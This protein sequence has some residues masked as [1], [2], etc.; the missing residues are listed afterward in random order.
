MDVQCFALLTF[1]LRRP[2]NRSVVLVKLSSLAYGLS[3]SFVL[4]LNSLCYNVEFL[5][6]GYYI[7]VV[8][9]ISLQCMVNYCRC[10]LNSAQLDE[11]Y[12]DNTGD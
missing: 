11:N 3:N 5:T 8:Y 12:L 9:W 7:T 2:N 4:H 10:V 1:G 6:L